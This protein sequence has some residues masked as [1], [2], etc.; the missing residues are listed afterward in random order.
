MK[1]STSF[2]RLVEGVDESKFPF[3]EREKGGTSMTVKRVARKGAS[4]IRQTEEEFFS[5][6]AIHL[7]TTLFNFF[8][9]FLVR[10]CHRSL[11][12]I[13]KKKKEKRKKVP[14]VFF[15][16]PLINLTSTGRFCRF[17]ELKVL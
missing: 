12:V 3:V 16:S 15:S 8:R 13:K 7:D 9:S 1:V 5:V 11:G 2:V 4:S 6:R 10:R 14:S 17:D